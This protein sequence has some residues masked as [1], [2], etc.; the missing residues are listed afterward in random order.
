MWDLFFKLSFPRHPFMAI[1][2]NK[3][4]LIESSAVRHR[5]MS[6]TGDR[7][8]KVGRRARGTWTKCKWTKADWGTVV[9]VTFQ[10]KI[11]WGFISLPAF[12][13]STRL[14]EESRSRNDINFCLSFEDFKI[15]KKGH[16]SLIE[17]KSQKGFLYIWKTLT[18][19]HIALIIKSL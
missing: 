2:C 19:N 17:A 3:S 10:R 5:K 6:K 11:W 13:F 14:A 16:F 12:K 7:F 9:T 18:F 8:V 4:Q 1:N 15:G